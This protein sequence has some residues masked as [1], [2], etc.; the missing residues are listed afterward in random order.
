MLS[1]KRRGGSDRGRNCSH[2]EKKEIL[3]RT[4]PLSKSVISRTIDYTATLQAF[5]EVYV[6]PATPGRIEKI[7]V[8]PGDRV[9]KGDKLFLMDQTQLRQTE[10][11]LNSMAVDLERMKTLLETGSITQSAYDQLKTSFDV[12]QS[13]INFMR[14]NTLLYAPYNGVIT[15]KYYENGEMFSGAPNT[16]AGKAAVVTLMQIDPMKAILNVSEK[17]YPLVK[18]GMK[19][20]VTADVYGEKSFNGTVSLV[21]PII[22]PMTRSFQVEI[23]IP[24]SER[25][26]K[27]G[28]FARVSMLVG[29]EDTFI[30]PSNIVLQQEG[31]NIRY[32]FIEKDG[33]ARRVEITVG[34][35]FDEKIEIISSELSFGDRLI[36]DG[37]TKV[38]NNDRVKVVN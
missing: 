30:V 18:K 29:E 14:E 25:N 33:V 6:A 38:E 31:T 35:R 32:L 17:Y 21:Y 7:F 13:S 11:Q 15:G 2:T 23:S 10:I 26:L 22:N 16:Q 20:S 28:M 4:T 37:Q 19:A 8:E 34:K 9:T 12:T 24:N 27:P 36:I 3:V 1:A 5:E